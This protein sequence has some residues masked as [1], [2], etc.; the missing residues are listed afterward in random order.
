MPPVWSGLH[1]SPPDMP[2]AV[3]MYYILDEESLGLYD[4]PFSPSPTYDF[5]FYSEETARSIDTI[6]ICNLTGQLEVQQEQSVCII[7]PSTDEVRQPQR[8]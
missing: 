5:R 1:V 4:N 7:N 2:P 6:Y 8:W 3:E